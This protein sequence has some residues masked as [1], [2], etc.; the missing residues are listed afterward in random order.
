MLLSFNVYLTAI[1]RPPNIYKSNGEEVIEYIKKDAEIN[2]IKKPL[3]AIGGIN[4]DNIDSVLG[5]GVK[6]AAVISAVVS[7][8]DVRKAARELAEKV[9]KA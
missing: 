5:Q 2:K 8:N 9:K 1:S 3:I 7:A 4:K 6:S